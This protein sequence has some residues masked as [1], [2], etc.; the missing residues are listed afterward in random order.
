MDF[1]SLNQSCLSVLQR[2]WMKVYPKLRVPKND[3]LRA[4]MN[5]WTFTCVSSL[6]ICDRLSGVARTRHSV[7]QSAG[8]VSKSDLISNLERRRR[9]GG[10]VVSVACPIPFWSVEL[11]VSPTLLCSFDRCRLSAPT[12]KI[13]TCQVN[14]QVCASRLHLSSILQG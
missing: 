5:P 13:N 4:S 10:E 9:V 6:R 3:E 14:N 7:R 1:L 2:P 12:Y 8:D 11:P